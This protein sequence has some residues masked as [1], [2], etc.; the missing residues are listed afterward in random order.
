MRRI[1]FNDGHQITTNLSN[2]EVL[3]RMNRLD[4]LRVATE[5]FEYGIGKNICRKA[6]RAYNKAD[7]FTGT[8]RL[9]TVEKEFLDYIYHENTMLYPDEREALGYYVRH[10]ANT[11][12]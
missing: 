6:L 4:W 2:E 7:N 11:E 1:T 5:G 8:I 3:K 12:I 9:N 10:T